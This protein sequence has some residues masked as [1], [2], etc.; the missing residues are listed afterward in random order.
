MRVVTGKSYAPG[1]C[2]DGGRFGKPCSTLVQIRW[3]P[4]SAGKSKREESSAKEGIDDAQ[5]CKEKR[6]P[7]FE[8]AGQ[9][10][11]AD[12]YMDVGGRAM[13]EQLPRK[14]RRTQRATQW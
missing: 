13:Q 12:A 11:P 14:A 10:I 2:V 3:L 7:A 6:F 8:A 4:F 9:L 5:L 1:V